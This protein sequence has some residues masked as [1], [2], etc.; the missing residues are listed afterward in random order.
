MTKWQYDIFYANFIEMQIR[1]NVAFF[2]TW[3]MSSGWGS[4]GHTWK[5]HNSFNRFVLLC[6]WLPFC[7]LTLQNS[8]WPQFESDRLPSLW[9]AKY[10]HT[11]IEEGFC[12][13][14]HFGK[15]NEKGS[16]AETFC[17]HQTELDALVSFL[18]VLRN[19]S[20]H[21]KNIFKNCRFYNVAF[22]KTTSRRISLI[23]QNVARLSVQA[24]VWKTFIHDYADYIPAISADNHALWKLQLLSNRKHVETD[25]FLYIYIYIYILQ[26]LLLHLSTV[27]EETLI[28]ILGL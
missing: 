8:K 15:Q 25:T 18:L 2:L 11:W 14:T 7:T 16:I 9:Q 19:E 3:D 24:D 6:A 17:A 12:F 21:P 26:K 1:P 13:W 20:C 22:Q 5:R 10:V 28:L 23:L 4:E 27:A